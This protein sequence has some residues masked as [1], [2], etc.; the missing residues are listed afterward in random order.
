M[1]PPAASRRIFRFSPF[2][3][4]LEAAELRKHGMRLQLQEQ[5]FQVLSALLEHPGE[6]VSREDLIRRLWNEGTNV[7]FDRGLNAAVTRL[8]QTLSDSAEHPRYIETVARRGYRFIGSLDAASE[9]LPQA[10]PD[11][12]GPPPNKRIRLA[13]AVL[14]FAVCASGAVWWA[15]RS[16][17]PSY[18]EAP[19]AV[20]LTS[21]IGVERN[22]SLSPDGN[23]VAFESQKPGGPV[24]VYLKLVGPGEPIRLTESTS[25]ELGPA[26]SP[27][28]RQIAF[29][30]PAADGLFQAFVIPALGGVERKVGRPV[31]TS[32]WSLGRSI[33]WTPDG[34]HI[35]VTAKENGTS[36]SGLLLVALDGGERWLLPPP[37]Q[38]APMG[39]AARNDGDLLPAFSRNGH[40]LAFV[41]K[42]TEATADIY[43]VRLSSELKLVGEPRRLTHLSRHVI[44]LAWTPD[45][46]SLLFSAG[47][48]FRPLLYRVPV[49]GGGAPVPI[50]SLGHGGGMPSISRTG[51]L[52][53]GR[54]SVRSAIWRQEIPQRGATPP[55]PIKLISS[56][57]QD[58]NAHYSPDGFHIA[59]QSG[60]SGHPQIWTCRSG[61][62]HCMQITNLMGP[63]SGTPRWSPD[64]KWLAFDSSDTGDFEIYVVEASG[65]TPRCLTDHPAEDAIPSFSHD[66]KWVYFASGRSGTENIWRVPAVGGKAVQV[67]QTG[68]VKA[69]ESHDGTALY[70]TPSR[71]FTSLWKKNLTGRGK[72]DVRIVDDLYS[73]AWCLTADRIYYLKKAEAAAQLRYRDLSTGHDHL[74]TSIDTP[75]GMGLSATQ[76]NRFVIYTRFE[77]AEYDLMLVENFR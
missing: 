72:D 77:P 70:Y 12:P 65:G 14:G 10:A 33:S 35:V 74:V 1:R 75:A 51:K 13:A 40:Q 57:W 64:G 60:R 43:L 34:S 28:G 9:A 11:L 25:D 37:G 73:R 71:G 24:H 17:Q 54:I 49:D 52:V 56:T 5:P 21:F 76:D 50:H 45:D 16:G 7:D 67:T 32:V 38:R 69:F 3:I 26:W 68:G 39:R 44:G 27:D 8:R 48:D 36:G 20:P 47:H 15:L 46:K 29:M 53:F 22:P 6:I 18:D 63:E 61:G 19:V 58:R 66:G 41:R 30:R 23:Q 2:E 62:T 4:D 55:P 31:Q 42:P 59:F